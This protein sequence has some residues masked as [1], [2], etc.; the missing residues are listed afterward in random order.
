LTEVALNRTTQIYCI[1][2]Q[3]HSEIM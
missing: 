1:E 3:R 2:V